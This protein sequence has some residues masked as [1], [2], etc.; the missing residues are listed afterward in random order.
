MNSDEQ[1]EKTIKMYLT[2]YLKG[3]L[4]DKIREY[5]SLTDNHYWICIDNLTGDVYRTKIEIK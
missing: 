1:I 4:P 5:R 2:S 3:K